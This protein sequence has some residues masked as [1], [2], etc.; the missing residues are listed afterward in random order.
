MKQTCET[1]RIKRS[2]FNKGTPMSSFHFN[3]AKKKKK[4]IFQIAKK[5]NKLLGGGSQ[6]ELD[7]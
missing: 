2:H 7:Q 5:Q 4:G 1:M 3:K 6:H